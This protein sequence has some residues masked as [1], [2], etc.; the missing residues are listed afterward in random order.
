LTSMA[1]FVARFSL[2]AVHSRLSLTIS[3][4]AL[5]ALAYRIIRKRQRRDE[6]TPLHCN[7]P[8]IPSSEYASAA[9]A[10]DW[11]AKALE[12]F[13]LLLAPPI[14][15]CGVPK[16]RLRVS[17]R[18]AHDRRPH[19]S[20]KVTIERVW[21]AKLEKA[22]ASGGRL[23]D[24]SKFRLHRIGWAGNLMS[25]QKDSAS[26][27]VQLGLTSYREYVC[28]NLLSDDEREALERDG[29]TGYG[30]DESAHLSNALGC[31]AMLITRDGQAVLLRRSGAVA[32][33]TGL[34]NGPSGHAE[35]SHARIEAHCRS[36]DDVASRQQLEERARDELYGAILQE[37][38]EETNLALSDLSPP[39]LIG[40]MA[41]SHRKP[42]LLFLV[43]TSLDA[44]GVRRAYAKGASEGWESDKLAFWPAATLAR[45][46]ELPL[47]A[48]T[49]AAA[50]CFAAL[51]DGVLGYP[52]R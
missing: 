1:A 37:V 18:P 22:K 43:R 33:G 15:S 14:Q 29:A 35:P 27:D 12:P 32:T 19:R 34:Y 44:E 4:V 36:A 50:A 48:V 5:A 39:L 23:F 7:V 26:V 38:H 2:S 46:T 16:S 21:Q 31:E 24:Q 28:S 10:K 52:T 51:G 3:A 41:D 20:D 9:A 42:D 30:G 49:R 40:A 13:T 11:P 17:L 6:A 45:C 8:I 25:P 47:T